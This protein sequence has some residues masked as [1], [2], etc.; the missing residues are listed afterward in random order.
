MIV[1]LTPNPGLDRT[2]AIDALQAGQVH[3][4]GQDWIEAGGKGVNVSRVLR[5][6][7]RPTRAVL[8]VGGPTGASVLQ[9]LEQAG[10]ETVGV[11]IAGD[12]RCNI[13]LTEPDGTVTKVNAA[14]PVLGVDEVEALVDRTVA[15]VAASVAAS[16]AATVDGARDGL[17]VWFVGC[18]SLT[19]GAP[20]DLFARIIARIRR[21][22]RGEVGIAIDSS[23]PAL[24]AALSARPDVIKPNLAELE[25][26]CGRD[27]A[28]F[29]AVVDAAR[30]L[31]AAGVGT[32]LVSLGPEGAIEV[33]STTAQHAETPATVVRT[34]VGAGDAMLA[35]HLSCSVRSTDDGPSEALRRAVAFGAAAVQRPIGAV[36]GPDTIDVP[37][38]ILTDGFEPS[39]LSRTGPQAPTVG[40]DATETAVSLG[41]RGRVGEKQ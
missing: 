30:E 39:R 25:E 17:P 34:T 22:V 29:G 23:G 32:V 13:T 31:I 4:A 35:G 28:T 11:P 15:T 8:P 27:L 40:G 38:V 20:E 26:L 6:N 37:A 16:V 12:L 18:G 14:G 21:D 5:A 24:A 9:L 7:G 41:G 33:T 10:V 1:T 36:P 3:R 2:Y 19:P